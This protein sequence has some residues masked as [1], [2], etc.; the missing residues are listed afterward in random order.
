MGLS[1]GR[2]G[3]RNVPG[4]HLED[5]IKTMHSGRCPREST[6]TKYTSQVHRPLL[7]PHCK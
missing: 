1:M 5:W 3:E 4:S 6:Q 2:R 7:M